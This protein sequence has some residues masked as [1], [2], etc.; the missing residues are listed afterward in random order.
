LA[1]HSADGDALFTA[2]NWPRLRVLNLSSTWCETATARRFL[3][4]HP[5]I[6]YLRFTS[7]FTSEWHLGLPPNVLPHLTTLICDLALAVGII[8]SLA[9]PRVLQTIV[10]IDEDDAPPEFRTAFIDLLGTLPQLKRL[11]FSGTTT[12]EEIKLVAEKAPHLTWLTIGQE[13]ESEY[14][15]EVW[16]Y[17]IL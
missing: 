9:E 4:R 7:E 3:S 12:P 5:N 10:S 1:Y 11:E 6:E 13:S 8:R 15:G 17:R 2:A 14:D 16:R